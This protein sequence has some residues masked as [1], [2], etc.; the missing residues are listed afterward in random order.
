MVTRHPVSYEMERRQTHLIACGLTLEGSMA[1]T[2]VLRIGRMAMQGG[3]LI[4]PSQLPVSPERRTVLAPISYRNPAQKPV[5][6]HA[7][8]ANC[9]NSREPSGT[10]ASACHDNHGT[11]TASS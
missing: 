2:G 8:C 11:T 3:C 9:I 6:L 4:H 10:I 7:L 1:S 5:P